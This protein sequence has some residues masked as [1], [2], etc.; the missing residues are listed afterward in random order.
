M[1]LRQAVVHYAEAASRCTR[2]LLSGMGPCA[3]AGNA[4]DADEAASD[5]RERVLELVPLVGNPFAP[6]Y[7]LAAAGAL[8]DSPAIIAQ[9]LAALPSL[10]V[11]AAHQQRRAALIGQVVDSE[12]GAARERAGR[13]QLARAVSEE[14]VAAFMRWHAAPSLSSGSERPGT[15]SRVGDSDGPP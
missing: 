9:E 8:R 13:R 1:E 4:A 7:C 5:A 2:A 11:Q 3:L 15:S 14:A 12:L 6:A 10:A